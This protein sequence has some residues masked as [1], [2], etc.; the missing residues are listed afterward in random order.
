MNELNLKNKMK[1]RQNKTIPIFIASE[2]SLGI[3]M[4]I[5]K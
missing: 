4:I 3:S 1:D 2:A 5:S